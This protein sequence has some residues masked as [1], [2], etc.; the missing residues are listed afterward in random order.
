[1]QMSRIIEA[2]EPFYGIQRGGDHKSDNAQKS[3]GQIDPLIANKTQEELAAELGIDLKTYKRYK[4]LGDLI[5]E[6]QTMIEEGNISYTTA[7]DLVRRLSPEEQK[8]LS[9]ALPVGEKVTAAIAKQY[10]ALIEQKEHEVTSKEKEIGLKQQFLILTI[11]LMR[12]KNKKTSWLNKNK[13][14]Y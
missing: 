5:P 2:L 3:K 4:Q 7:S 13:S 12:L 11:R 6:F 9:D 10:L 1:M 14:T 8:T